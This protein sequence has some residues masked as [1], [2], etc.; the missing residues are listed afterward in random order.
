[1]QQVAFDLL[2]NTITIIPVP[3]GL[4]VWTL[5]ATF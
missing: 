4:S 2:N 5:V 1:M 3:L